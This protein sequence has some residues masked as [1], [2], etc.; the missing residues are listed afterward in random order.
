[1]KKIVRKLTTLVLALLF[2]ASLPLT[3][4]AEVLNLDIANGSI[5]IYDTYATQ[6]S[7]D[8]DHSG[9]VIVT[10]T[11]TSTEY[12]VSVNVT[13]NVTVVLQDTTINTYDAS[14]NLNDAAV[15]I[16][17]NSSNAVVTVELN[18]TNTLTSD[19]RHAGLEIS[20]TGSVVIQDETSLV[21][22]MLVGVADGGSLTASGGTN[23]AGIGGEVGDS[24]SNITITGGTVTA[25]GSNS[26]AGIGGGIGGSADNITITGGTVTA[27]GGANAAGI[28]GGDGGSAS[29][30]TITGGNVT[31]NGRAH[32]AGIGG[33][34]DGDASN[35]T[36]TGGTVT[37]TGG[38]YAA[39][40]GGGELG[41]ASNIT[42]TGGT[43][44]ATGGKYAAGIGAGGPS[45]PGSGDGG[46]V[47]SVAISGGTVTATGGKG[48][49]GIGGEV[50]EDTS[51]TFSGDAQVTA[52]GGEGAHA[53]GGAEAVEPDVSNLSA[54]GWY[55]T[56]TD[57]E[58]S[59][60]GVTPSASAAPAEPTE[61]NSWFTV[62]ARWSQRIED[63]VLTVTSN[64]ADAVLTI[65]GWAIRGLHSTGIH[66]LV[67]V[68]A[69]AETTLDIAKLASECEGPDKYVLTHTGTEVVLTLNGETVQV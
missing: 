16:N 60:G 54:D 9:T 65:R 62:D 4:L 55:R 20:G 58:I 48:G 22:G 41:D 47:G 34:D 42:I 43:V 40:I 50:T 30:I 68:T 67:F 3:A 2:T 12:N 52:I 57:G 37:A 49:V 63:G 39:G 13:S 27:N 53:I 35:I 25:T 29:N 31:A 28:G 15:E 44:T 66:T 11:S 14:S 32:G 18:G 46:S 17:T 56:G 8:H 6:N 19:S 69:Q 23:S 10:G 21:E 26:A 64:E 38:S 61:Q 33:G 5:D 7:T 45:A 59:D 24:A 1:M 36:I 51:I